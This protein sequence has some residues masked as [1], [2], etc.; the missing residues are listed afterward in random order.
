MGYRSA[1]L[2]ELGDGY[3]FRKLR[4]P[5]G[6]TA[7]GVNALVYPPGAEGVHHFHDEQDE[8]YFVHAGTARFEVEDETFELG[9]GGVVHVEST[10]PR[11]ISNAGDDDL[12]LLVVGGKGGYVGRDGRLVDPADLEKRQALSRGEFR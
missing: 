8:L 7:F 6:V 3:G 9:P 11:K 10:T 4:Q 2:D 1:S 5:L 12:V